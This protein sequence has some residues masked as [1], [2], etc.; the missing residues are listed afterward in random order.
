MK[1]WMRIL[2]WLLLLSEFQF[3][4]DS[5]KEDRRQACYQQ[6]S[7]SDTQITTNELPLCVQGV[8]LKKAHKHSPEGSACFRLDGFACC[9]CPKLISNLQNHSSI[10]T[11]KK[12]PTGKKKWWQNLYQPKASIFVCC[13]WTDIHSHWSESL[14]GFSTTV[15]VK[16]SERIYSWTP[17]SMREGIKG[18]KL[19]LSKL[20][21]YLAETLSWC[22]DSCPP[23]QQSQITVICQWFCGYKMQEG[24]L[25]AF[26]L[27]SVLFPYSVV[28][29]L[30]ECFK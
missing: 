27:R 28:E 30:L 29:N 18:Y 7:S 9:S 16:N 10:K 15:E 5:D 17:V 3:E 23:L 19:S 2:R 6:D 21:K 12:P 24:I 20:E 26:S 11:H 13:T 22:I 4:L 1:K 14:Q 25:I 8:L